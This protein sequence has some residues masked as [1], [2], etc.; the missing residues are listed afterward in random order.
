MIKV[1]LMTLLLVSCNSEKKYSQQVHSVELTKPE[2]AENFSQR[3]FSGVVK[4]NEEIGVGFK[5]GGQ[6][7]HIY[8]KEGDLV[9]KDQLLARLDDKDISLTAKSSKIRY[10][11]LKDEV[12]RM[13]KIFKQQGMSG[14][15]YEKAQAG[16]EQAQIQMQKD[17][18]NL[19]Y[20][21]LKAP[22]SGY[23]QD[24]N[25]HNAEM[26]GSG[27]SVFTLLDV[28]RFEIEMDIPASVYL[29]YKSIS[30]FTATS[31]QIPNKEYKLSLINVTPKASG[32]QLYK[33][34]LSMEA[35]AQ[36]ELTAGMNIEVH[37]NMNHEMKSDIICTIPES[38]LFQRVDGKSCVWIFKSDSTITS[39]EVETGNMLPNGM[40]EI[41]SGL[42]HED[43]IIRTGA[44]MLKENEKVKV[45]E[46][47][48]K[49][50]IGGI[51]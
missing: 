35:V 27:T 2:L 25:F 3:S 15:D 13:T 36:K 43:R 45:I 5:I 9:K 18:N 7:S 20:T 1:A 29:N 31:S 8:V 24:V 32:N 30:S 10:N 40:I 21:Y 14:N 50:N 12:A 42:T 16:L 34:R 37:I 23:I 44:D 26:V 38:S 19:D 51:I 22:V 6:I 17:Q 33:M 49:S 4:E 41:K 47:P 39:K 48:S 46:A 11:Q 28:N